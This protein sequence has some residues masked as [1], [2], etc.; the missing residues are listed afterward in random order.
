ME[1]VFGRLTIIGTPF[2]KRFSPS[3]SQRSYVSTRC[4]CGTEKDIRVEHIKS[5]KITSCGCY[6]NE[7][8][9]VRSITH[10]LCEKSLLYGVWLNMRNRCYRESADSY[11]NYGGRGITVC[12]E[13]RTDYKAFHEW[14]MSHGY[15]KGLQIDRENN[16]GN[17][18][19]NNCR[20][21]TPP[22][23]AQNTRKSL[24]LHQVNEIRRLYAAIVN[25]KH[26]K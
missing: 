15:E 12:E 18:E 26:W 21:I 13:W 11:K 2:L 22:E 19:P 9:A 7:Q 8:N 23:N 6:R 1:S 24:R 4:I 5:G 20:W 25:N 16:D 17:Y 14:C 3:G 10:G